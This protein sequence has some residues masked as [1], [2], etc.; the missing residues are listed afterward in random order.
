VRSPAHDLNH[1]R[2]YVEMLGDHLDSVKWTVGTR[3]LV[4][5]RRVHAGQLRQCHLFWEADSLSVAGWLLAQFGPDV[6]IFSGPELL[7]YLAAGRVGAFGTA[8]RIAR[9]GADAGR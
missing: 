5:A 9:F 4:T 2:D 7:G 3:R 6:N 1:I 8:G